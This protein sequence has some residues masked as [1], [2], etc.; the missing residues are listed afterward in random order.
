MTT[1]YQD[2]GYVEVT[3]TNASKDADWVAWRVY[4]RITTGPGPWEL[5]NETRVNQASY[6]IK[7]Y[8]ARSGVQYHY[9]VVQ[10]A[11]RSG[12]EVESNYN[13]SAPVTPTSTDYWLIVKD[14]PTYN[15]RLW[16]VVSDSF[17]DEVQ[18][19][20]HEIIGR[21][22]KVDIGT[23]MGYSGSLRFEVRDMGGQSARAQRLALEDLQRQTVF[24]VYLRNPFGDVFQ[25]STP[26]ISVERVAGVGMNEYVDCQIE[27]REV[28]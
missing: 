28:S 16:H 11:S 4:R 13:A 24:D 10:V 9:A 23:S 14:D 17:S 25:V 18:T 22:R 27:Y 5:V 21:G 6:S 8:L 19:Q 2:L 20:E 7:D 3:F 12:G 1:N 15:I 26:S